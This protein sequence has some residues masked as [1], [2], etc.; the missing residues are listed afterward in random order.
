LSAERKVV[1]VLVCALAAP[2]TPAASP[3]PEAIHRLRQAWLARAVETVQQYGGTI[4]RLLDDGFLALFGAPVAHEDHALRAVL[5]ATRLPQQ[6]RTAAAVTALLEG[7]DLALRIGLHT[8]QVMVGSVGD[9]L[10]LTVTALGDTLL[11]AVQLQHLATPGTILLSDA[12][13]RRV[14]DAVQVTVWHPPTG[15]AT[16]AV[17][18]T[19]AL[20]AVRPPPALLEA[21]MRR[22]QS[23]FVGRQHE[24][25][26]VETLWTQ[27]ECGHGQVVG[28][29]GHPG[30]GKSRLL[31][32]VHQ[33]LGHTRATALHGRCVSYGSTT[34]YLPLLDLFRHTCQ[35]T[36]ADSPTAMTAK[37]H[38]YLQA[39]GMRPETGAPYVLPLL[40][41]T[42]DPDPLTIYSPQVVRARTVEAFVQ[43][44]LHHSRQRPLLLAIEDLH[45][46]DASSEAC[47]AAL[48][49][50][51]AGVPIL[52]LVTARP[53]YRPPWMDKS[54]ATQMVL[55][56][57]SPP[58]SLTVLQA[59]LGPTALPQALV[60]TLV[61]KAEGNPFFLEEFARTVVEH[62]GQATELAMPETVQALLA[63]RLDRL[64]PE[65]KHLVQTAAVIGYAVPLPVLR[66]MT[67][68]PEETL[69]RHL[70]HLQAAEFLDETGVGPEITY[71]FRHAL[72]QEVAYQSLLTSTRQQVHQRI[73]QVFVEHF[74]DLAETQPEVVAQHYTAAGLS[75]Q[76]VGY[77]QRAAQRA[78][79]RSAHLEAI[80]HCT[81]GIELLQTLPETP[82]RTQHAL[83][84][85]I[86]LGAALL[87]TKG[88]A[89]PVVEQ[90]YTQARALCQQVGETPE[91]GPVLFGLW[92]FY[93]VQPQL[94][95]ARDLGDTLL[96]L[97]QRT[98]DPGLAVIAHYA[99]GATWFFLGAF[100]VAC[101]HMEDGIARYTPD[102]R[103]APVFRIGHDPGVGCRAVAALTL[104][105]LGYPVQALAR[106]HEALALAHELSHPYSLVMVQCW[107]AYVSQLRRDVSAVYAH[108]EAAVALSTEQGF[109]QWAAT[110]TIL[111]GWALA[112]Q[113]QGEAGIAQVRQ[114][115][116][117]YRATGA[118]LNIPYFCTVLADV[119]AHLGHTEDGLQTL[120]E[121]HTLVEQHESRCWEAEVYRLQGVLLLRQPG[122]PQA[123]AEAWLQ[124]ALDVARRQEAKSLELRAAISLARLWQEQG[125]RAEARELLAPIYDW[126]TEGFDTAD[127]QEA[128][129]VLDTRG[130]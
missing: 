11:L 119:A 53:G 70:A 42:P 98:H 68:M 57:L 58:E 13:L 122:T 114:G 81:T 9:Q 127:L 129:T 89:A 67:A 71:T 83:T 123:E 105:V 64:S 19:Y 92:R 75:E 4:Q 124:R 12:T 82:E 40:G 80:S 61:R 93:N 113:G 31:Y 22:V 52:L 96:R 108:A 41:V 85:Y 33:R 84:L 36:A 107:A 126:F 37:V 5:T 95:T 17:P 54:Y 115:I 30:I 102:Q 73:A 45:W 16:P 15:A 14:Q 55:Q 20:L 23:R 29:G 88:Q 117:A 38:Q 39:L 78:S 94:H 56:P 130:Q 65:A 125:K 49:D 100:P 121:A 97:A 25:A 44:Y 6:L 8:G 35:I 10:L 51:L 109:V 101:Q 34:P 90:A 60:H 43:M 62:G 50:R 111:R 24:F 47:L 3:E 7:Q 21:R 46:I 2:T 72:T 87:V 104:W 26:M 86:A 66:K 116:A 120:A 18:V 48:V 1:T 28:V 77:W 69:Q 74:A 63:A 103:R 112:R 59:A 91:L 110:G 128:K 32:E 118:M 76:A 27:V 106:L 79:D 99:L